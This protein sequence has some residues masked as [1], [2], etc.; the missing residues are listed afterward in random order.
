MQRSNAL[1]P[2][3]WEHHAALVTGNRIKRGLSRGASPQVM[4]DY[5][6]HAWANDIEH[7][8]AMEEAAFTTKQS[9]VRIGVNERDHMLGDHAEFRR[10]VEQVEGATSDAA[11]RSA[12]AAFADLLVLHV[13]FEERVLFPAIERLF[14]RDELEDVGSYLSREHS[15]ACLTWEPAFWK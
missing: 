11:L 9:W 6:R 7:H 14:S 2:L 5:L 15:D 10:L 12:L 4:R 3:S 8:F 13:R 1:R